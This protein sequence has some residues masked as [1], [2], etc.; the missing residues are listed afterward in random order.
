MCTLQQHL[1]ISAI[2]DATEP[3]AI[4]V[5]R[6]NLDQRAI[7]LALAPI[8]E[9]EATVV[10]YLDKAARSVPRPM[11]T[12]LAKAHVQGIKAK[13]HAIPSADLDGV[14]IANRFALFVE[15]LEVLIV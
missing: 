5:L 15:N 13:A 3:Q 11:L 14:P 7:R 10:V 9:H 12:G 6:I 2:G 1:P 4:A 8:R